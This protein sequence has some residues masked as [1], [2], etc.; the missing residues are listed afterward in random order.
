MV[1]VTAT[2]HDKGGDE[3]IRLVRPAGE[4]AEW[5]ANLM[6]ECGYRTV[7]KGADAQAI[8]DAAPEGYEVTL[9]DAVA[10]NA[11]HVDDEGVES[12]IFAYPLA[13]RSTT[14]DEIPSLAIRV[15]ARDQGAKFATRLD[16]NGQKGDARLV[17]WGWT[18]RDGSPVRAIETNGDP[19]FEFPHDEFLAALD[20]IERGEVRS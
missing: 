18:T 5:T 13:S 7:T 11:R 2:N 3:V 8:L 4:R 17:L 14:V 15:R 1:T 9:Q 16:D 6:R 19:L 10:T 12:L 20:A